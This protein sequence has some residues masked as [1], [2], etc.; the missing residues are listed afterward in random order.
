MPGPGRSPSLGTVL[1]AHGQFAKV[2]TAAGEE[3]RLRSRKKIGPLASGDRVQW[4]A[5]GRSG[6]IVKREERTTVLNRFDDLGRP[7]PVAANLDLVLV[8]WAPRPPSPAGFLDRYL[9]T[10]TLQGLAAAIVANKIDLDTEAERQLRE[11]Q[12]VL[13]TTLEYQWLDVSAHSQTGL[14]AL[15]AAL[16]ERCSALVGQSGVGKSSLVNALGGRVTQTT[17]N[18]TEDESHGRHTTSASRLLELPGAIRI[19]DSPGIRN[20]ATGHIPS[21]DLQHGF[22]EVSHHAQDCRFRNCLHQHEPGCA[23]LNAVENGQIDASRIRSYLSMLDDSQ[24]L[25]AERFT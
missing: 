2:L 11:Q 19:I 23:V 8:V 12:R 1:S 22:P 13:Y 7:R 9:A 16:A 6:T 18:L 15:K 25:A 20:F 17:G 3:R 21:A 5:E 10:L 4:L 24:L 14:D